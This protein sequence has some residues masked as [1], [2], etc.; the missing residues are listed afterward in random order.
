MAAA[1][2]RGLATG[3]RD[4]FGGGAS[5]RRRP[6][7]APPIRWWVPAVAFVALSA[8]LILVVLRCVG[9]PG[10]LDDP[11]PAAQRDGVLRDGPRLPAAL[12]GV[13]FGEHPVVL[14]FDRTAPSGPNFQRCRDEVSRAGVVLS[15]CVAGAERCGRLASAVGLAVP[16]DGGAPI[17]YAVIDQTRR[18]RYATL[19][20]IYQQNAFEVNVITGALSPDRR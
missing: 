6:P 7:G 18:V 1:G 5:P 19:D 8:V 16:V 13:R 20:P 12:G 4:D 15:V 11:D 10:P 17:G 9:R 3:P 2:Q 14:L